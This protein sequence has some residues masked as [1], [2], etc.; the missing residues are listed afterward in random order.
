[1]NGCGQRNEK[2]VLVMSEQWNGFAMESFSFE[3]QSAHVVFPREGTANGRLALKTVYWGAFPNAV[4][5]PLLEKG[6]HLCFVK[7]SSRWGRDEDLDRYARLVRFVAQKYTLSER[8][9]PVGMSCGGLM[10]IK[11]AA[12]YPGLVSCLYLDAPVVN[13]LSCPCG[14]GNKAYVKDETVAELFSALEIDSVSQLIGCREMPLDK[15][16][17]LIAHRIPVV[18]V[19]GDSDTVVPFHENGALLQRAYEQAGLDCPVYIK[20]GCDHHP[21]GLDDPTEVVEFILTH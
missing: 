8:V 4:E 6:F 1:M 10:A 2:E 13:Y 9:V 20:P 17:Q 18:M 11:F 15:I 19:A 16:P 5:V 3:G 14:M 12:K 7:Y 21:H